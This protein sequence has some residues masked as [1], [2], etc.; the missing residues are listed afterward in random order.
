MG[1]TPGLVLA[2]GCF[3]LLHPG[4][5]ALLAAAK[6]LG[7]RLIVSVTS[8]RY[9]REQKGEGRPVVSERDRM[10]LLRALTIVDGVILSD[11]PTA[12]EIIRS[13]HPEFFVKGGDYLDGDPSGRLAVERL[14]IERCGG[15]LFI[16][17]TTPRYSSTAL[18]KALSPA[19]IITPT[20]QIWTI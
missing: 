4:H 2:H 5:L 8:D 6:G 12:V 7:T 3:E 17:N 9:V 1:Y 11:A 10:E 19:P 13:L 20:P 15:R 16:L 18:L 14:E